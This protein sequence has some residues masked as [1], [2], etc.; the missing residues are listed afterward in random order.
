[1]LFIAKDKRLSLWFQIIIKYHP[2]IS[3]AW[4]YLKNLIGPMLSKID[5]TIFLPLSS[6]I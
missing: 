1:M 3:Y 2:S 6:I 4:Y 5:K